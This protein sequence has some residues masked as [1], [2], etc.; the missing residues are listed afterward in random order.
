M[1]HDVMT[2]IGFD[3]VYSICVHLLGFEF[4]SIRSQIRRCRNVPLVGTTLPA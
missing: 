2:S 1:N 4:D 3:Q